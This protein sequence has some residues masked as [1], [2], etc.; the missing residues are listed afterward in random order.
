MLERL[1]SDA[2]RRY[3]CNA[4]TACERDDEVYQRWT[5]KSGR[6]TSI[7]FAS[8][9]PASIYYLARPIR[10][11]YINKLFLDQRLGI[12]E[13]DQFMKRTRAERQSGR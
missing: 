11:I 4:A 2:L 5:L 3:S 10:K 13:S 1:I 9:C 8:I 12:N 6:I 7:C